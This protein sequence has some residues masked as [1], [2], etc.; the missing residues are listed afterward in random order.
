MSETQEQYKVGEKMSEDKTKWEERHQ[1]AKDTQLPVESSPAMLMQIALNKGIDVDKLERLLVM[2]Q[3]W[4]ENKARQAYHEAMAA[5]KMNPPKIWRDLQ[6][7]YGAKESTGWSHSDLGVAGEAIGIGLAEHGLNHTWRTLPQ[8]NGKIRVDCV[9]THKLGHSE[10]TWL[11]S[12]PDKT[13]SKNDIQAIGSAVFYLERYTLFAIT[14]LAP[15]RM[16]DDGN[17]A[18]ESITPEQ[19][20]EIK[21]LLKEKRFDDARAKKFLEFAGSETVDTIPAKNYKEAVT[22]LKKAAIA[23]PRE[24]VPGE[25]G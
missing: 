10:S 6:V 19:A 24:R 9:I 18:S 8:E 21:K 4:E 13:G 22:N 20:Q 12:A 15:A 7:K 14:G 23:K 5:F 17:A 16:D 1:T 11:D 2:Q 25:E 3:K